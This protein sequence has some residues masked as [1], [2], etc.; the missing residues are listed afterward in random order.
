MAPGHPRRAGRLASRAGFQRTFPRIAQEVWPTRFQP[1]VPGPVRRPRAFLP[2]APLVT[3]MVCRRLQYHLWR[4][5]LV[6][7]PPGRTSRQTQ[8]S[9]AH[10]K[11]LRLRQ[12]RSRVRGGGGGTPAQSPGPLESELPDSSAGAAAPGRIPGAGPTRLAHARHPALPVPRSPRVSSARVVCSSGRRLSPPGCFPI[13]L[14]T[15]RP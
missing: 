3:V 1:E 5:Y 11:K 12:L 6:S 2:W 14:K 10:G 15:Q 13:C 4:T 7:S 8:P 9:P